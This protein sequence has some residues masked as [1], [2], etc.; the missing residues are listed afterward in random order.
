MAWAVLAQT[1][2]MKQLMLDL[3]HPAS[4]ELLLI[5]NRGGPANDE[6]WAAV[7]RSSLSLAESGALLS[8]PG[9]TRGTNDWLKDVKLLTEGGSAAYKAALA[10]DAMALRAAAQSVDASCTV[11][12][13]QF[14]PDVF[15]RQEGSK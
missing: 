10:K 13:K 2:T 3:I 5:V 9:R 4:N 12:H 14:R 15:P 8:E 11:C 7:R 6:E 1:P